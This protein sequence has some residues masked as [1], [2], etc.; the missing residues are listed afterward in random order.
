MKFFLLLALAF[1]TASFAKPVTTRLPYQCLAYEKGVEHGY[2]GNA[3]S[4]EDWARKSALDTCRKSASQPSKCFIANC[5]GPN[6]PAPTPDPAPAP[7]PD[8][9]R[10]SMD[11]H[12][13]DV[14]VNR[15]CVSKDSGDNRCN[16]DFDCGFP[17]QCR[18]GRCIDSGDPECSNNI[19]C[20]GFQ[21]CVNRKCVDNNSGDNRCN[22][23][24][25]CGFQSRCENG[26]CT[27]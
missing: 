26:Q 22:A 21:I 15:K 20:R 8:E 23:D 5:V 19:D 1:P 9:C 3:S 25:D 18:G 2:W 4:R 13:F 7:S 6:T 11:C 14:C 10:S 27:N 24:F 12:G 17:Q 16:G